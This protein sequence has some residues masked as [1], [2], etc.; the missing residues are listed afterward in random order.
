MPSNQLCSL[1]SNIRSIRSPWGQIAFSLMLGLLAAVPLR[2]SDYIIE[3]DRALGD[4]VGTVL[5]TTEGFVHARPGVSDF[6]DVQ[7]RLIHSIEAALPMPPQ[8]INAGAG[9]RAGL[10][11]RDD[12]I[13]SAPL[14]RLCERQRGADDRWHRVLNENLSGS[15]DFYLGF[16]QF[17]PQA[18]Q[19]DGVGGY[20][21]Y[22]RV[23]SRLVRLAPDCHPE[24]LVDRAFDIGQ[25][26]NSPVSTRSFALQ[27]AQDSFDS[28][29]VVAVLGLDR[30]GL[31][32]RLDLG[33][34][35]PTLDP[36]LHATPRGEAVLVGKTAA[37]DGRL[38][39][40]TA[41]GRRRWRVALPGGLRPLHLSEWAGRVRLI[42][43]GEPGSDAGSR[44][45]LWSEDGRPLADPRVPF[46]WD[47]LLPRAD[48]PQDRWWWRVQA[49]GGAILAES[50]PDGQFALR[51][52][53]QADE[54]PLLQLVGGQVVLRRADR[55]VLLGLDGRRRNLQQS[56]QFERPSPV[57]A[58]F[59]DF[60][61][62]L[63]VRSADGSLELRA[64][65]E[66]REQ[67][68]QPLRTPLQPW[69]FFSA[70]VIAD[71]RH[72]CVA[73]ADLGREQLAWRCHARDDGQPRFPW[74]EVAAPAL[75]VYPL[76]LQ[77]DGNALLLFTDASCDNAAFCDR[78]VLRV[79]LDANGL[80]SAVLPL[81]S[82]S[83]SPE[84]RFRAVVATA[85]DGSSVLSER[86]SSQRMV[87]L[88]GFD[89][90]GR[91]RWAF[92]LEP[93]GSP[94]IIGRDSAGDRLL[95]VVYPSAEAAQLLELDLHSGTERWRQPL[96]DGSTPYGE[97]SAVATS[98]GWLLMRAYQGTTDL[99]GL[100]LHDGALRWTRTLRANFGI[101][102]GQALLGEADAAF[103]VLLQNGPEGSRLISL[104]PDS[105]RSLGAQS[106]PARWLRAPG[107]PA[108]GLRH[109][110]FRAVIGRPGDAERSA[111]RLID[112]PLQF[113]PV[114]GDLRPPHA[115]LLGSWFDP[116]RAGQGLFVDASANGRGV[117]GAWLTFSVE[118][119]HDRRQLRWLALQGADA[120]DT[121]GAVQLDLVQ[122]RG[123]AF[124]QSQATE[125]EVVGRAWLTLT[126]CDRAILDYRFNLGELA[127]LSGTQPLQRL[128]PNSLPCR[129]AQ[130]VASRDHPPAKSGW[131]LRSRGLW[132]A[133]EAASPDL[134]IDLQ[135]PRLST[136]GSA[137]G[138]LT[139]AWFDFD[140]QGAADDPT[141]QH[142]FT[143]SGRLPAGEVETDLEIQ[144]TIGGR[145]DL[146]STS[147]SDRVGRAYLRFT[148][149]DVAE[150]EYQF[151][152][153]ETAGAFAGLGGRRT[154]RRSTPCD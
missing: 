127:G 57:D 73:I 107:E 104:D 26:A 16:R 82:P 144:R 124:L 143:L 60:G 90:E 25:V 91:S 12:G 8:P 112:Q 85:A 43:V 66:G 110:R 118:G 125:V 37:G 68:R 105:G 38:I 22:D 113:A 58:W 28:G 121:S 72:A 131:D 95:L 23:R 132:Q 81:Q 44:L 52:L 101:I 7:G 86:L 9:D 83:P 94:E 77:A 80:A 138:V 120:V 69:Q 109:G 115:T 134:F 130:G 87:R 111:F 3:S 14:S 41:D 55:L 154:I 149:C 123:G 62:L 96:P 65:R 48:H 129:D 139:A 29:P 99:A 150:F 46:D 136:T 11:P 42:A 78:P 6:Y 100:A 141:A 75:Q 135:P 61:E 116:Q 53:L 39:K 84:V 21:A 18:P 153:V 19:L 13:G 59:D 98:R 64:V 122:H 36:L 147:N 54:E 92:E 133:A 51:T 67:W 30:A 140:P 97:L 32:W 145:F 152:D 126:G 63:I 15:P 1:P 49:S 119:G 50:L 114:A 106:L 27:H 151:D 45:L 89:A 35:D 148:A 128:L 102:W 47:A 31:R 79:A 137:E 33:D 40:I 71:A 74:R 76:R 88:R 5:P 56:R 142:W 93:G 17:E 34:D 108:A 103:A 20:F 4:S 24:L 146:G 70:A 117:A 10:L 2:A